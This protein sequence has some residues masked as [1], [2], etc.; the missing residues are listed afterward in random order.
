MEAVQATNINHHVL[1][2]NDR[3]AHQLGT[4]RINGTVSVRPPNQDHPALRAKDD[5]P[6]NHAQRPL[7]LERV[8]KSHGLFP[9]LGIARPF[10]R[11]S[12][13]ASRMDVTC[14]T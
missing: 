9:I 10:S 14:H 5:L 4:I 1:V 13:T 12:A 3:H 6:R 7:P 2:V 8:L 11:A